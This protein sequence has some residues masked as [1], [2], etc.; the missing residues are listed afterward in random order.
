MCYQQLNR[1][2]FEEIMENL[3]GQD[4]WVKVVTSC[5]TVDI[6]YHEFEFLV[7]PNT[8]QY[9]FGHLEFDDYNSYQNIMIDIE[10][11]TD[12]IHRSDLLLGD[13][14]EEILLELV[15]GTILMI[16]CNC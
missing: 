3:T 8:Q 13:K 12:K 15:D 6:N 1:I 5:L 16:Q 7:F 14:A 9:Q 2:Q 10:N 11:L 4:V